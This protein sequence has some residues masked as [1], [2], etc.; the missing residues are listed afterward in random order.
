MKKLQSFY[1]YGSFNSYN[2]LLNNLNDEEF[3]KDTCT[4]DP[5]NI[6]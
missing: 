2:K 6:I 4:Y 3:D 5:S 1:S